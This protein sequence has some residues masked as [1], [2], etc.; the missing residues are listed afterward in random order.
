ML[1]FTKHA[2]SLWSSN[3]LK[4]LSSLNVSLYDEVFDLS[5]VKTLLARILCSHNIRPSADDG[6]QTTAWA[7]IDREFEVEE[8]DRY[9]EEDAKFN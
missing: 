1:I 9:H 4:Y 6:I 5:F 2:V 8:I 3:I 7:L